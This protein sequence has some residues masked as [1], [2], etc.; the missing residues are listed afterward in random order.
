MNAIKYGGKGCRITLGFKDLGFVLK[1]NVHNTGRPVPEEF[2]NRLFTQFG[3]VSAK[4]S[5]NSDSMG[6]GLYLVKEIIAK[7]GGHIWYEATKTGS[8]FLFTLPK[9]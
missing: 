8:N 1:L 5:R 3:R 6:L 4:E 7:H 2:R 9:I